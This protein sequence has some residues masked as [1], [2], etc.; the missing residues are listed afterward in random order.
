MKVADILRTLANN[1]EHA[2]GG[3]PDPRISYQ[4]TY[5]SGTST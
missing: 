4:Y 2:E 3:T 1:L 5:Y